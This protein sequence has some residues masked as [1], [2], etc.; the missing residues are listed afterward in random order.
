MQFDYDRKAASQAAKRLRA[1]MSAQDIEI[2]H[3]TAVEAV[4]RVLAF[5]DAN[6][7]QA[8]LKQD[9]SAPGM[10]NPRISDPGTITSTG[11]VAAPAARPALQALADH[12]DAVGAQTLLNALDSVLEDARSRVNEIAEDMDDGMFEGEEDPIPASEA[13]IERIEALGNVLR[14]ANAQ[15]ANAQT[16]R[17]DAQP[18]QAAAP[19]P[20]ARPA[21]SPLVHAA[22]DQAFAASDDGLLTF[23][24]TGPGSVRLHPAHGRVLGAAS[25]DELA[26]LRDQ[27]RQI[28]NDPLVDL[29]D[30][31]LAVHEEAPGVFRLV[32]DL[33]PNQNVASDLDAVN[34]RLRPHG[35]AI[36]EINGGHQLQ[37]D[38][39]HNAFESDTA[40]GW[41]LLRQA[42]LGDPIARRA[43]GILR[44]L[45]PAACQEVLAELRAPSVT[46]APAHLG[47]HGHGATGA[48]GT[49]GADP[50]TSDHHRRTFWSWLDHA[51]CHRAT[52]AGNP[53]GPSLDLLPM[54]SG[55]TWHLHLHGI[56][57]PRTI[58][59]E[60]TPEDLET[61][62]AA[63]ERPD[64]W[65]L[66]LRPRLVDY[67]PG[68]RLTIH[69]KPIE[70]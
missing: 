64:A 23:V 35:L 14:T 12:I 31:L 38:D 6:T 25:Q 65:P 61:I 51:W 1:F 17:P 3:A 36:F 9:E 29:P 4:A 15:T 49:A 20:G 56:R 50:A 67:R 48:S 55:E 66:G 45:D 58:W 5:Q 59:T 7:M 69:G 63:A 11:N 70:G 18:R 2:Q 68:E 19:T 24:P 53:K 42:A 60:A 16:G 26:A 46:P 21:W 8:R 33:P 47:L 57:G 28:Q 40:A 44:A 30:R 52:S 10:S 37:R 62:A 39:A 32:T 13:H 34:D 54:T 41:M 27:L 22:V 43:F